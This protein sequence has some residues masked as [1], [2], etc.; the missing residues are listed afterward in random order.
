MEY[1]DYYKTLGISQDASA[2]EIKKAYR[3]LARRYHP[4]VSKEP[5]AEAQFKRIS[6]AYEV[7]KDPEKRRL[8]DQL[9]ENYQAG[10]DFTPPPSGQRYGSRRTSGAG[11]EENFGDFSDFF[12]SLFGGGAKTSGWDRHYASSRGRD[13]NAELTID[14][15]DVYAG[16]TKTLTLSTAGQAQREL[17]VKIPAG[18]TDGQKIR[19]KGQGEPSPDGSDSGDLLI[20]IMIRP[21]RHFQ[22]DGK[23]VYLT[24]PISPWEAALGATVAV[25]TLGGRVDLNIPAESQ[26]QKRLR[27]KG[28]GLPGKKTGDQYVSLLIVNP[29]VDGEAAKSMFES[30]QATLD[31]NP[32]ANLLSD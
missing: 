7:L 25:P 21:H 29:P 15:E 20:R 22:L 8:Y 13:T 31:F 18:V 28:R 23:D 14:L 3:R 11:T 19:L 30:M 17:K 1:Q 4:D 2:E 5:D 16:S 32:R 26:S 6:E 10:Q 24:L 27:L 9:G 12:E